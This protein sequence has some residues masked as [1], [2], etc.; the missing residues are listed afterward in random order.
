MPVTSHDFQPPRGATVSAGISAAPAAQAELERVG[1]VL[2]HGIGSQGPAET[3]LDWSTPLVELL[4]DW[5]RAVG[6]PGDPVVRSEFSFSSSGP[7]LLEL[8]IPP[9]AGR[10]AARW[11]IT[12]AWWAAD[13][14]A[15]SLGTV[16]PYL[17]G[18]LGRIID[19]IAAGYRGTDD[20]RGR[21][22][23]WAERRRRLVDEHGP[24]G[25]LRA[26]RGWGWIDWLDRFQA[27]A[28]SLGVVVV[29]LSA[30]GSALLLGYSLLRKIPVRPLQD[31]AEFKIIDSF[32]VDW[33]GDL[34]VL[35]DDRVQAAN[36]RARVAGAIDFLRVQGADAI[37]LVAH[38]GGVIVSFETLLDPAYRDRPVDKLITLGQG[39]S[40]AWRLAAGPSGHDLGPGSRLLGDLH[41]ARPGLRWVDVWASYDPAPAGPLRGVPDAPLHLAEPPAPD[42]A[43]LPP[44][45]AVVVENRPVTNRMNVLRDHGAYWEND[46]GF[47]VALVRHLDAPRD[48]ADGS[49]FYRDEALR[50]VRIERRRQRVAVLAAWDWLCT[51]GAAV[52]LA[53]ALAD[54]TGARLAGAGAGLAGAW[55]LVP[56]HEVV[57]GTVDGA[58][59]LVGTV[60]GALGAGGILDT[61][62]PAGPTVLGVTFVVAL[63]LALAAFGNDRWTAW[64]GGERQAGRAE[65]FS[66][67]DRRP[68]AAE[69]CALGGGL[70]ALTLA[71]ATGLGAAA[72]AAILGGALTGVLVRA[73]RPPPT[74]VSGPS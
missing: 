52:G 13:L 56:G 19:G 53:A 45:A 54:R 22:T 68:A 44:G 36:V 31:F 21:E 74:P 3:F 40:L 11:L 5:R 6:L 15:P 10:S 55:A 8:D 35:L 62:A 30:L 9:Y 64:D 47:L 49:R 67:P 48:S 26:P 61:L 38:S 14:R 66:L 70:A 27:H 18:R 1:V 46:E 39:L 32:L 17:A 34:P 20:Y 50:A 4:A 73:F 2:V 60:G 16:V 24:S 72:V 41:A 29:I 33:F 51:I 7:P 12:E 63:F 71:V 42:P 23:L 69:A 43:C 65:A 28:F 25:P 37:V 59:R 58:G 57:S